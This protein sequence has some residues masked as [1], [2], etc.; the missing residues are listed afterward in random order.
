MNSPI[1]RGSQRR[2][3]IRCLNLWGATLT[4]TLALMA[5]A[6]ADDS[7]I[8]LQQST[9]APNIMLILDTSGSMIGEVTTQSPYDPN[10]D[11]VSEGTGTCSGLAGRVFYK[12]G[13]NQGNPPS[14]SGNTIPASNLK[15]AKAVTAL[16]SE[17]GRYQ[18]D[19][20]IRWGRSSGS[21]TRRWRPL[22]DVSNANGT[23][24]DCLGDNGT[25]GNLVAS[26][27]YPNAGSTGGT[28][29][30]W[31]TT[32]TGSY[33]HNN[34]TGGTSA[35]IYSANYVVYYNQFRVNQLGTRL[36]VMQQAARELLNSLSNVN[37]GLMRFSV[38]TN[39]DNGG[40]IVLW[41]VSPIEENRDRLI[42]LID[43]LIPYGSTPLSEAMY[44]A[45]QYFAGGDVS[46]GNTSQICSEATVTTGGDTTNC[47]GDIED[48]DS[49]PE[50]R[51]GG[52]ANATQY[53]SPIS[54]SCQK[55]FIVYLT[56][57]EPTS[58]NSADAEIEALDP[59]SA[60]GTGAGRCLG[61][62][63]HYMFEADMNGDADDGEQNVTSYFIGFGSA[64]GGTSNTAFQYLSNA[65]ALGGTETAHQANDLSELSQVFSDIFGDIL[66]QSTTLTAPT[67]AV[68]A[69]NRTQTLSDLYVSVFQPQSG[70]HWPGNIKKYRVNSDG[71]L[72][73]RDGALAVDDTGF[74]RDSTSDVWSDTDDDADAVAKGGAANKLPTPPSTRKVYTY[75]GANPASAVSL[76]ASAQSFATDNASITAALL[77]TD[78][79][80]DPVR[81]KLI[82]WARGADVN[83][84]D[85]DSVTD[86]QRFSL[87]D[88]MH[89]Q[90]AIVIYG[91]TTA[92]PDITDAVVFSATN[93]GYV[94][95]AS[96]EDGTEL[97]AF[98]P[99]E[100]F[101]SL[102]P[103]YANATSATKHYGIDGDL[104]VLK[105]DI[106]GDGIVDPAANDRVLLFFSTGRNRDV[107]R[108]YALDITYKNTPKFLWA[109]GPTQLPGLGQ[110]WS[111]PSVTRVNIDGATQ[112][113]Q[114]LVLVFGGGYDSAEE[115][116]PFVASSS[117]GN[118][119]Y[120]VD[121]LKGTLLWSAG[122]PSSGANLELA[123]MGHS[124]PAPLAVL[125]LNGDGYA[126]RM[127]AGDMAA[128][129]WRFDIYNGE[130]VADLVTGGVIASLGSKEE[131]THTA[132]NTRRFYNRPDAA[133][134]QIANGPPF[135]NIAI[136][137]GYRGR[138]LSI[139]NQDRFYS[140]RDHKAFVKMTQGEYDALTILTDGDLVDV[141][142]TVSP[143][144]AADAAGWKMLLNR[145]EWQGEKVLSAASTFRNVVFFTTYIPNENASSNTC[146]LAVGSN[147]AY[148]VSAINASPQ[149]PPRRETE[150]DPEDPEDPTDPPPDP[151]VDDRYSELDQGG[152]APEVTFL[153]PDKDQVV[154]LSGVEVLSAC[155]DFNS[156]IKTYWRDETAN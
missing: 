112:N 35:A 62:L 116:G 34:A 146:S 123:R 150:T 77:G 125:D 19:R 98:I 91:G 115:T 118:R 137:S 32:N 102:L 105:Y 18:G 141:T 55:N 51:V 16:A 80:A 143:T 29:G 48:F 12:T 84:L 79:S 7:E 149:I 109:L 9:S 87:G 64:F 76:T 53:Q 68:N 3:L 119:V 15:C 40:G 134:L 58:D 85:G 147:R 59:P 37:V 24:V 114:K 25:D 44:E 41:P 140:I 138:P 52:A 67:V 42:E 14:C 152:I 47:T 57:G 69:F 13:W 103:L 50:S 71:Q 145:P 94:H 31:T 104:R 83:D 106:N 21:S 108:Y 93:D 132:A 30:V 154:C 28:N 39:N 36:S 95:A 54:D 11:Y 61:A 74:F 129:L 97:W 65:A 75:I 131:A 139:A 127:Y 78:A 124:I 111:T 117:S 82:N 121:A 100:S 5:S 56:D 1:S 73:D 81:D 120:I 122:A 8:F 96:A 17:A 153:F 27:A 88:P 113:S 4:A 144:V 128:Q 156:R 101:A 22:A 23:D 46:F 126:D 107:S 89:S 63:S 136:G 45:H 49:V 86:E 10:R 70:L 2:S 110:A 26:P 90:P 38:N 99:Q 148:T 60:C 66:D 33:W 130:A 151:T 155:K 20:Y 6:H 142:T 72:V 133:A 92:A 43:G 135:I